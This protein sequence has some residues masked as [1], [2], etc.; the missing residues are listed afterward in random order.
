MLPFL[1]LMEDIACH[2]RMDPSELRRL[3]DSLRQ[4][5]REGWVQALHRKHGLE[6][7]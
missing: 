6:L 2:P 3:Q 7:R 1:T 4:M 5:Y